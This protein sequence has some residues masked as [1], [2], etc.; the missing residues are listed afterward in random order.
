MIVPLTQPL[1][2]LAPWSGQIYFDE[3]DALIVATIASGIWHGAYQVSS[4]RLSKVAVLVFG[5][6]YGCFFIGM[7][8][9]FLPF[10]WPDINEFSSY[11]SRYNSLRV[12]KGLIWASALFPLWV[13]SHIRNP[14]KTK[15]LF[16][17]GIIVGV[18]G[19]F[20]ISLWERKV[21]HELFFFQNR[22]ALLGSLLDFSTPYRVTGVFADMHTGGTAIDG[23]ISLV[24]PFSVYL[25][26]VARHWLMRLVASASLVGALYTMMVTFS[27]GVY[28]GFGVSFFSGFFVAFN[29]YPRAFGRRHI[30]VMLLLSV[31]VL[32]SSILV[33]QKGGLIPLVFGFFGFGA[34]AYVAGINPVFRGW[35]RIVGFIVLSGV[36]MFGATYG[37]L[38]SKWV[39][40]T[41]V[42][43]VA[44]SATEV[45]IAVVAGGYLGSHFLK[46]YSRQQKL[47]V[48]MMFCLV[49][50]AFVPSVFG[51]R[52][53]ERFS[54]VKED[55]N[56]RIQHWQDAINS[57]DQ[58]FQTALFGQGIGRFPD[59]YY[60]RIQ[61]ARDVGLFVFS[62]DDNNVFLS[63][64][65]AHDLRLGQRIFLRPNSSY[66]LSLD[67]RTNDPVA[68]LQ[69]RICHRQLIHPTEWNP[70]CI[71]IKEKIENT[72]AFW[73]HLTFPINSGE[74]GSF[75]K[76][77]IAPLVITVANRREYAFNLRPQTV[78]E[79]DNL[80]LVSETGQQ[81]IRNGDFQSGIDYWFGY[82][83]FNH[84][85][86]HIKNLWVSVYFEFGL[87]GLIAFLCLLGY[88]IRNM[89]VN[90]RKN[91]DGFSAVLLVSVFGFLAVGTFG[92]LLDAPR[93]AFLFYL[94][95]FI[96]AIGQPGNKQIKMA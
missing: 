22:Y 50:G 5:L 23:Y 18:I 32:G 64:A 71:T 46:R 30:L 35:E 80:S 69:M 26:W 47:L 84:L 25:I 61:G 78:L 29:A 38:T 7:F 52:M 76:W 34:A 62:K 31:A 36:C 49:F 12:S 24:W 68:L 16:A 79:I 66:N 95:L 87:F 9:G 53:S 82:Y 83:D 27:R 85:P 88:S 56:H 43:A 81:V 72:G 74:L 91:H 89:F 70:S 51:G 8:H 15:K 86:W 75:K 13:A 19:V 10:Q 45:L 48:I 42:G 94:L 28:L 33:F 3:F 2:F 37:M 39:H 73:K 14:L 65:G 77:A 17:A 67:V 58:D 55:L 93:V 54:S 1:L 59:V 40:N 63:F 44:F 90:I 4:L 41:F 20:L 60:W 96:G 6:F 11:Y 92:T 21:L 57:M